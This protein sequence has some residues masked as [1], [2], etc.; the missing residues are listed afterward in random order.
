[1]EK[2]LS[3]QDALSPQPISFVGHF[4]KHFSMKLDAKNKAIE[5][6]IENHVRKNAVPEIKGKIT[7]GKIKW[8]GIQMFVG[9]DYDYTVF[10]QRDKVISPYLNHK[11]LELTD[12][13][14][15][16][17]G[18]CPPFDEIYG[19]AYKTALSES[20]LCDDYINDIIAGVSN[21]ENTK[22]IWGG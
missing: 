15:T 17:I 3:K 18:W 11:T 7:N 19:N 12:K 10:K 13:Q 2:I 4:M 9:A 8:R 14:P 20:N 22:T 1:M 5:L 16:N 6:M 21:T